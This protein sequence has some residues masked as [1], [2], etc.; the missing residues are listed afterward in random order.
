MNKSRSHNNLGTLRKVYDGYMKK[1]E[2]EFC[3]CPLKEHG[4]FNRTELRIKDGSAKP[5][6]PKKA[7]PR[8]L[9]SNGQ[10]FLKYKDM[11]PAISKTLLY[12]D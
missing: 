5:P 3:E 12:K 10:P 9:A 1:Y 11:K 7:S 2:E 4:A 6:T 8:S